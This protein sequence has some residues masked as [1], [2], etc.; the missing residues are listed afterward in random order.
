ME[1]SVRTYPMDA[2]RDLADKLQ[3]ANWSLS[4]D[5]AMEQARWIVIDI[6][7][8]VDKLRKLEANEARLEAG[9]AGEDDD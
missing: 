1:D 8:A 2:V 4:R 3:E 6:T 7:I 9:D 5:D